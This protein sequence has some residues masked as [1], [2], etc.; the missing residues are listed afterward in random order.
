MRHVTHIRYSLTHFEVWVR[1]RRAVETRQRKAASCQNKKGT[2]LHSII[3]EWVGGGVGFA[4]KPKH[5]WMGCSFSGLQRRT[6]QERLPAQSASRVN[7]RKDRFLFHRIHNNNDMAKQKGS[8]PPSQQ[9][10]KPKQ[11]TSKAKP[12]PKPKAGVGVQVQVRSRHARGHGSCY[13]SGNDHSPGLA[14]KS[15]Q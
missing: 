3:M 1:A 14:T 4:N 6:S 5:C 15:T 8:K 11:H 10:T 9:D 7:P 13:P 2:T 12:S